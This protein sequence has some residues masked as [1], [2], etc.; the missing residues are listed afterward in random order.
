MDAATGRKLLQVGGG[1][2]EDSAVESE[3]NGD[4]LVR[5][6]QDYPIATGP[7]DDVRGSAALV[8]CSLT[9]TCE[10]AVGRENAPQTGGLGLEGIGTLWS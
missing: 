3:P 4:V 1:Q 7:D 6:Q 9:G 10:I 5:V 2:F 8:R